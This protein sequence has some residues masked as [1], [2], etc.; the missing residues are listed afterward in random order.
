MEAFSNMM[1]ILMLT[2]LMLFSLTLIDDSDLYKSYVFY[3]FAGKILQYYREDIKGNN[4][5]KENRGVEQKREIYLF[6]KN[7]TSIERLLYINKH[8]SMVLLPIV[9]FFLYDSEVIFLSM[10]KA[11]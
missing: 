10:K 1:M 6:F 4:M 3:L 9:S 11:T 8:L 5:V 7:L 2:L